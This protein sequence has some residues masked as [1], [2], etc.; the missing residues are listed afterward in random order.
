MSKFALQFPNLSGLSQD[1]EWFRATIAGREQTIRFHDYAAIFSV[2]G[3]Y[4][5]LFYGRLKCTSPK[6]LAALLARALSESNISPASLR[7]LD[8]GAGNGMVGQELRGLDVASVVGID[9]LPEAATATARD[10]PGIYADYVIAD[11]TRLRP[12]EEERLRATRP[13]LLTTVAALGFG[14]IPSQAFVTAWNLIAPAGWV[15]FNIKADFLDEKYSHGFSLLI[16]RLR[17]H[18]LLEVRSEI[19]YTHRLALDGSPLPY[20]GIVGVKKGQIPENWLESIAE[21]AKQ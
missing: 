2:P 13:N 1:Q 14:D 4:E 6:T 19:D 9:I 15:V 16:R 3:L 5:E 10:R 11:L 12:D 8:V 7:G 21:P 20:T 18:G 17:E